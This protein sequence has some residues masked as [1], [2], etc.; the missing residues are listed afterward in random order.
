[1]ENTEPFDGVFKFTNAS[2]REFVFRWNN[3]DYI[4]P[5]MSTSP[6]IM[7]GFTLEEVQS[8]RKKAALKYA[9][10]EFDRSEQGL[11]IAG[12]GNKHLNPATYDLSVLQPYVDQ[13]LSPLPIGSIKIA[14]V[15]SQK[16]EFNDGG[17]ALIGDGSSLGSLSS[18][19]GE[20]GTYVP[21]VLGAMQG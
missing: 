7:Q 2:D 4:F 10:R 20:F 13:C 11:K 12:E 16:L 18:K 14:D 9:Q 17:T 21:P 1:M 15:P 3:K 8:I 19:D 6:L 5:P